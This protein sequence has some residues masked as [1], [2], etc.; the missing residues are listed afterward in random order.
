MFIQRSYSYY[1]QVPNK[2]DP[3]RTQSVRVFHI[4]KAAIKQDPTLYPI[5]MVLNLEQ[6]KVIRPVCLIHQ[7]WLFMIFAGFKSY[8]LDLHT[9]K[10]IVFP[11]MQVASSQQGFL[12]LKAIVINERE[13]YVFN[14]SKHHSTKVDHPE[15]FVMDLL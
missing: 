2:P 4:S 10:H 3:A 7:R 5:Q 13:M 1:S 6:V 14:C 15:V 9:N 8:A 11:A 12:D